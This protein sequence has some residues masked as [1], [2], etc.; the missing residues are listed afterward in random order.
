MVD[1][2]DWL[3][4]VAKERIIAVIRSTDLCIGRKMAQAVAAG[5]I[6]P[7]VAGPGPCPGGGGGGDGADPGGVVSTVDRAAGA[8]GFNGLRAGVQGLLTRPGN[9]GD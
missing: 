7:D 8:S 3:K 2:D 4:L 6:Y 5:G 1:G 9:G